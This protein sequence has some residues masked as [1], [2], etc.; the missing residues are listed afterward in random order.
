MAISKYLVPAIVLLAANVAAI[1]TVHAQ[2]KKKSRKSSTREVVV[3]GEVKEVIVDGY[4]LD[5]DEIVIRKKAGKDSKVTVEIKD[6][7]ILV[8]GKPIEDFESEDVSVSK[9]KPTRIVYG[10]PASPFRQGT[11]RAYGSQVPEY[12]AQN[13]LF[14][15][16]PGFEAPDP[17]R[18]FL[19]ISTSKTESGVEILQVT[20]G[21][22][23]EKAGLKP[24]DVIRT[25]DGEKI[26]SPDQVTSA[27]R[28]HKIDDKIAI[29]YKR[30]GKENKTTATLGKAETL[31]VTGFKRGQAF[32]G[33][34]NFEFQTPGFNFDNGGN[35]NT[36]SVT[37]Y[38]RIGI[39][40]QDTEDGNGVKV[41]D[42]SDN[43]LAEKAGLKEDDI[44]T[45]LDGK[46]ITSADELTAA[47]KEARTKPSFEVKYMRDGKAQTAEIKIP[48]K[49]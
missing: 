47:A 10:S 49:L 46:K 21:S 32:D 38:Q 22:G 44:I 6:D 7:K 28:K 45:S 29:Y 4:K 20:S 35:W 17:D 34:G 25:I 37:G 30:D 5:G 14:Q 41:L 40:A 15:A 43:S 36:I 33:N 9:R 18:A 3:D 11:V 16:L 24:G 8:N 27:I 12:E 42:V 39:R 1:D 13:R 26:E 2:D 23:A 31:T 19:G 48:K